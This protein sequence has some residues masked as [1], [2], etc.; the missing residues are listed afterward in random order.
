[1][2]TEG[3]KWQDLKDTMDWHGDITDLRQFT[4][5]VL[6]KY[7]EKNKEAAFSTAR[8]YFDP[9]FEPTATDRNY[10]VRGRDVLWT[11]YQFIRQELGEDVVDKMYRLPVNERD[12]FEALING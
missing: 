10:H 9:D 1:M 11:T 4:L 2:K 3:A 8:F 5:M 12:L 7:S 6:L